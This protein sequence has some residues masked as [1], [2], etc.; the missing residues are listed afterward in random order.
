MNRHK[1][2]ALMVAPFLIIGGYIISDFYMEYKAGQQRVFKLIPFGH[3]DVINQECI[4]KT[5]DF[6]IKIFD[7]AGVTKVNSTFPL[8]SA[9]LFLVDNQNKPSAHLLGMNENPYYWQAKTDLR[10]KAG[11][12]GTKYKL[13][14]IARIKGSQY[15]SEFYTQTIK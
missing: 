6:K 10:N 4:L 14:L 3:C 8:D 1:K 13:R 15:I 5:G 7:E 12:K 9:T 11:E 2:I